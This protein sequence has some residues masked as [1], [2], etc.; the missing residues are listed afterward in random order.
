MITLL[1]AF[2]I[3]FLVSLRRVWIRTGGDW[4]R[5]D[6]FDGPF[7]DYLGVVLGGAFVF[8]VGVMACI[9]YLP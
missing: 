1:I 2:T 8:A 4:Q 6:P 7:I 5:F 3:W 9:M